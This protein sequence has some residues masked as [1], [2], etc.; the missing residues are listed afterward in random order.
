[1]NKRHE[2]EPKLD[3]ATVTISSGS[4]L[5]DKIDLGGANLVGIEMPAGWTAANLTVQTSS[6]GTNFFDLYDVLGNEKE[7]TVDANR[8]INLEPSEYINSRFIKLRS[9]TSGTPVN[10]AADRQITLIMRLI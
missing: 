4:S 10:Q 2:S 6:D 9:G 1:M 3:K 8:A 5:S 7:I